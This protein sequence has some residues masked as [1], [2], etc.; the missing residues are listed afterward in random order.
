MGGH[1][2]H[3]AVRVM[4]A[5][6]LVAGLLTTIG[7][8][9]E[10]ATTPAA[11]A[12]GD[13]TTVAG[14]SAPGPTNAKAISTAPW[15]LARTG[16]SLYV[17]DSGACAVRR[18]DLTTGQQQI[19]A[20]GSGCGFAG[21]G[22]P[23]TAATLGL[24][25]GLALN[26]AGDLF[27]AEKSGRIRKIL[28]GSGIIS[29]IAG[30]GTAG[31]SGDGGPATGA[32][33]S[34]P[35]G[36]TVDAGGNVFVADSANHAIRRIDGATKIISTYA[37]RGASIAED[38]PATTAF[39]N[40]PW[41]VKMTPGGNIVVAEAGANVVR[42]VAASTGKITSVAGNRVQGSGGNG[43]PATSASINGPSGLAYDSAGNLLISEY[44]GQSSFVRKV[45]TATGTISIAAGFGA[46]GFSGDGGPA[47]SAKL[48]DPAGLAAGANGTFYIADVFNYRVRAV[49]GGTI[50][51]IAGN[52]YLSRSGDGGLATQAQLESP[53]R[54][55]ADSAG[56]LYVSDWSSDRVM[57]VAAGTNVISV[58][59]GGGGS[60]PGDGGPA[61]SAAIEPFSLA[62]DSNDNLFIAEK[63]NQRIRRVDA[64]TKVITTYAG[65][66]VKGSSGDDGPAAAATMDGPSGLSFDGAGN[67]YFADLRN[68]TVRRIA[69]TGSHTITRVA[70]GGLS[71]GDG[72]P[73]LSAALAYPN[74]TA[75]DG[76]GNLY[77]TDWT[78]ANDARV[79]KVDGATKIITTISGQGANADG[80]GLPAVNAKLQYPNDVL[81]DGAGTVYVADSG[82][83]K[84]RRIGT[85]GI[86]STIAGGGTA[87]L[88]DGG[89]ARNARLGS[90]A[91]MSF[92]KLGNLLL[93][94]GNR[95]V[96]KVTGPFASGGGAFHP[97]VPFRVLDSRTA[98]GGWSG[99][100][101]AGTP[102]PLT[103]TGVAGVPAT[104]TAV[105]LNLTATGG[106]NGSFLT[107][108]PAG[109]TQP[110]VGSNLNFGPGETLPNLATVRVGSGGQIMIANAVG[111]VHVVADLVGYFDDGT[112]PG[113]L[114]R[115]ITPVRLL[116]S[117]TTNG[118]W[119]AKLGP[120]N[121][122]ERELQI[123]GR[124]GISATATAVVLNV[125]A[126]GGSTNSFL[127]LYPTGAARPDTSNVNFAAG[128]TIPNL[129]TVKLG[130]GGRVTFYNN[131][132]AADVIAD[133][134][135][136]F[137][138]TA[139]GLRFH[140]LAAPTRVLDSRSHLG[141]PGNWQEG[142]S[143]AFNIAQASGF[144]GAGALI[145]NTTVT[146]GTKGS[147]VSVYPQGPIPTTSNLNFGPGQTIANL[148]MSKIAANGFLELYNA[149]GTVEI[150]GDVTGYYSTG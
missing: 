108:W 42:S 55:V 46:Q 83:G 39:L 106:S 78:D 87:G 111:T 15:A 16:N 99:S 118:G 117:R 2:R 123:T 135:G 115:P 24:V 92:D 4:G 57:R 104:A 102:R 96:R 109:V 131:V 62:I 34:D 18:L 69:A 134:V 54:A 5:V 30:T 110:T 145:M 71:L 94:D 76:N 141:V 48:A 75:V 6:A 74:G 37:G 33:L 8:V 125:T 58:Y 85:D 21:D 61:T 103:V 147:F 88:G 66:G 114:F 3:R 136:T 38:V 80:D 72:G 13:I 113:D 97:V 93:T 79:R 133:V 47:T 130:A 140:P 144:Q 45:T 146:Q 14:S 53:S 7:T 86:I 40:T 10:S 65:T 149:Q 41:D 44:S 143:R 32:Q 56:N 31:F 67:L 60:V 70:G 121:A 19:V 116:D 20:G 95:L 139:G 91:A 138:P 148:V 112:G 100:L 35:H 82:H 59:A 98:T 17:S 27:A 11:A 150:I 90:I 52:G 122:N 28:A 12:P 1:R 128:Q 22:G 89:P 29:T 124:E 137:D 49:V 105:I 81:V 26:A 43:G 25:Q 51:T 129:V 127:R 132:G 64:V 101:A 63:F 120:G 50:D 126:T 119:N 107:A 142:M 73:A 9:V 23:A 77:I 84:V 68:H 36:V